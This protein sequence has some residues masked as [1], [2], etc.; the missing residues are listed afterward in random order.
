MK[1]ILEGVIIAN[2]S[3]EVIGIGRIFSFSTNPSFSK[4]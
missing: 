3:T 4:Y 2:G 1:P